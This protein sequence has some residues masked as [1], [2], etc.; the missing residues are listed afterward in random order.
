MKGKSNLH[1]VFDFIGKYPKAKS[2]VWKF[3]YRYLTNLD[4]KA[5][6]TFMNYGYASK[7]KFPLEKVDESKVNLR[8]LDV[9]EVGCGRGGGSSYIMR[10]MHPKSMTG[11]DFS[12][13]AIEFC[14]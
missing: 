9:L 8:N 14:K 1:R 7:R 5:D 10:Y 3:W 12:E 2:L 6:M 13:N 11:L 4:K